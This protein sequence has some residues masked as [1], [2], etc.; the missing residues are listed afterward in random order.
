MGSFVIT[1]R[2]GFGAALI[3]CLIFAFLNKT[4]N[5]REHARTV[6]LGVV[7]ALLASVGIGALLFATVGEPW[8][9]PRRCTREW[10]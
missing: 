5:L 9:T 2:E 1:L 8:G 3:V 6:W 4:G 10:R 7:L